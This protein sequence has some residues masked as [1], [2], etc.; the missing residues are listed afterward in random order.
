MAC[1]SCWQESQQAGKRNGY[2]CPHTPLSLSTK[3]S[4]PISQW[5]VATCAVIHLLNF[6]RE[7]LLFSQCLGEIPCKLFY[8]LLSIPSLKTSQLAMATEFNQSKAADAQSHSTLP[9]HPLHPHL[10]PRTGISLTLGLEAPGHKGCLSTLL[11]AQHIAER[12]S[13]ADRLQVF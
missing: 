2:T 5:Q 10:Y 6:Q 9:C 11:F 13:H 3:T 4:T 8:Y 1:Q 7:M 12:P